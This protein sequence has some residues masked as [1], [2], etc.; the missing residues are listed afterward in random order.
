MD[1]KHYTI[2]LQKPLNF[3]IKEYELKEME[4]NPDHY[5]LFDG[6]AKIKDC[7]NAASEIMP[8][9]GSVQV[10]CGMDMGRL[11]WESRTKIY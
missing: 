3:L 4:Y 11:V 5:I 7:R 8:F 2:I 6:K 10:F 9:C 1:M